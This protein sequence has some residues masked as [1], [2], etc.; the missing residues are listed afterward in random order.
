MVDGYKKFK[1]LSNEI[2]FTSKGGE[3]TAD[4]RCDNHGGGCDIRVGGSIRF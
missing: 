3:I 2:I 1:N 4:I